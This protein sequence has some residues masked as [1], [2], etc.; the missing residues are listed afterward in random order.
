MG[1][2]KHITE[3]EGE[4]TMN[5]NKMKEYINDNNKTHLVRELVEGLEMK[6]DDAVQY[7][8]DS[9][10]MTTEQFKNKYFLK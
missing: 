3:S 5:M 10:T 8:Y 9:I 2:V 4:Q 1:M 7:V 6:V